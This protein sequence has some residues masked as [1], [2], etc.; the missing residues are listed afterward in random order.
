MEFTELEELDN[1][2]K[3]L[4]PAKADNKFEFFND[5]KEQKDDLEALLNDKDSPINNIEDDLL[6][7]N[8]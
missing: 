7:E 3:R 1:I 2:I 4:R 8:D 6:N 5:N